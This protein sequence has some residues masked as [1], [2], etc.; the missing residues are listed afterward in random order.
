MLRRKA[1][2][3]AVWAAAGVL[4]ADA[5]AATVAVRLLV[6]DSPGEAVR[7]LQQLK[8]GADF[9][10]LA[11]EKS[12]DATAV[13]GGFLGKIDPATLRPELRDA[14]RGLRPGALSPIVKLPSGY[15]VLK[16]LA[17][18][19]LAKLDEASRARQAAITAGSSVRYAPDLDGQSESVATLLQIPK[20]PDWGQDPE[21][22]CEVH[23]RA[24]AT[25]MDRVS[26]MLDPADDRS[27]AHR[28]ATSYDWVEAFFTKGN[29][30]AY[31][32]DMPKAIE[33]F[34]AAYQYS[35]TKLPQM[36]PIME[37]A[38]G[39][40][41]LQQSRME[42]GVFHNPG[43]R[44]IFPPPPG[45]RFA[46]TAS[47][48]KAIQHL[49]KCLEHD[50]EDLEVK[51]L[52]NVAESTLGNY[53]DKV[54]ARYL[55]APS[56]FASSESVGR[57][58]DVAA[59]AGLNHFAMSSG[60]VVDDF[61]NDGLLDVITSDYDTCAPMHFFHNNGDGTFSDRSAAAG[62]THELGGLNLVETDYNNDGCLDVLVLR[63]AWEKGAQRMSLLRNN[64]NG[65][66]TDV[67][68]ESGL[69]KPTNAQGAAWADINNDGLLDLFVVNERGPSQLYLN[70][71]D[72]T[73]Q[74][75]SHSAGID[76]SEFSKGVAAADY[77]G[78]GYVDFYVTNINNAPNFLY[79]NNRD[80]TFTD[81]AEQAGVPGTGRSFATWFFDYDN[82]G[83]PDLFVNSYFKS[84]EETMKTYLGLPFNA[85][86]LKLYKNLG[87]GTFRDVT[88]ET[89]LDRVYMPMG[90]NFGDI[91][92]DGYPDIY[93]GTGAP[94][95]ASLVP[96]V[97]LRNKEGKSF[98]DVT[99][100]SGTGELDKGHGVA[101]ADLD[102]RGFEDILTSIGG[103][104]PGDRHVFR[105]FENPGNANDWIVLRLVG[106]KANRAAIG[107][108][109]KVTVRNEGKDTRAIWHTV[110]SQSSFGGS[111]LRQHIGLGK[112]AEILKMEIWWPGTATPQTFTNVDKRQFIEIKEGAAAY[113]KLAYRPY[114]LGGAN[115]R[116]P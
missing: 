84:V 25:A 112:S 98:V 17:N 39:I 11:R 71:G 47:S 85:G 114:R 40:A 1:A 80:G 61:D 44:C 51:W 93:L 103:A 15:A 4:L 96:N 109:I 87:N 79:H 94:S 23:R 46:Q 95:Y 18:S 3:W 63:G 49:L 29:L 41:Y 101:F 13:D 67:T 69:S 14:L 45:M 97:L 12:T 55:I 99:A 20:P 66:F 34:E 108:R 110:G 31:V 7:I 19:D 60:V 38:L 116:T 10:V 104:T 77:D 58:T 107:A 73:F 28:N 92:N 78:D 82:D 111:P 50:P 54:P 90:A 65:T 2:L 43:E 62:I 72:G 53:P 48:E 88:K 56:Y 16:V 52:L 81:V 22:I 113:T 32:G 37:E 89:G 105:L 102:N 74:D 8:N 21:M 91:D 100:S 76:R 42:N 83:W 106:V 70:K 36:L 27:L 59:E 64:C 30:Y 26:R 75:I 68:K 24:Y 115:R 9:A 33:Q 6:V 5:V 35:Q 86:T 57:F